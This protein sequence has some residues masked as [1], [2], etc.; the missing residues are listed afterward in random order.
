MSQTPAAASTTAHHD[1]M[2]PADGTVVCSYPLLPESAALDAVARAARAQL[3]WKQVPL[4]ERIALVTRGVEAFV[5][6]KE[7][8]AEELA[9]LLGR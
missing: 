2:S 4:A 6:D 5:A 7:A 1:I 9:R 8:V 3:A